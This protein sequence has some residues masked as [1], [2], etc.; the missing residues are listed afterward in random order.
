MSRVFAVLALSPLLLLVTPVRS[1]DEKMLT[2]SYF[3]LAVGTK[4]HYRIG[5]THYIVHVT[6]HEK[7]GDQMA[8]KLEMYTT[9]KEKPVSYEHVAVTGDAIVRV[10]FEGKRLDPP[11]P[12]L[13]IKGGEPVKSGEPWKINSRLEG[14]DKKQVISGIFKPGEENNVKVQAGEYKTA[15]VTGQDLDVAGTKLNLTYY[16]AD[17]VGMV[18]QTM[19]VAGQKIVVELEKFEPAK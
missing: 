11:V 17:K 19:D 9:A 10:S 14:Q 3:P 1:A 6:K 12:F 5:E 4:W 15:T 8:A 2:S 18:K 16:F 7:V 13:K